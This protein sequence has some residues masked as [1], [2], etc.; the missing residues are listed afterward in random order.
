MCL[1]GRERE[2]EREKDRERREPLRGELIKLRF[3][4]LNALGAF[5]G[6]KYLDCL[7]FLVEK[8]GHILGVSDLEWGLAYC[9]SLALLLPCSTLA[10]RFTSLGCHILPVSEESGVDDPCQLS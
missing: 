9:S 6:L 4:S 8:F 3:M 5:F 7:I 1:C 2:R 10:S